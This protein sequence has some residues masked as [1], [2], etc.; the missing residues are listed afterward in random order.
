MHHHSIDGV[1]TWSNKA[2]TFLMLGLCCVVTRKN[3]IIFSTLFHKLISI[4]EKTSICGKNS[5]N[6]VKNT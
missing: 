1:S 4:L 3:S 6:F 5:S 2:A